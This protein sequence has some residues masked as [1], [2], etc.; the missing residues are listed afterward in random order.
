MYL[1]DVDAIT[2]RR[3]RVQAFIALSDDGNDLFKFRLDFGGVHEMGR[4]EHDFGK[5]GVC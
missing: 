3:E 4:I 1:E 5:D 2:V